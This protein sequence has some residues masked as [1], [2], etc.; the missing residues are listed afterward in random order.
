MP[1]VT[2]ETQTML[3][4]ARTWDGTVID[5]AEVAWLALSSG[6]EGLR[7]DVR[8]TLHGDP[9]PA[10]PP[11]SCDRLWEHEVVELFIAGKDG[12]YLEVELGPHGHYLVLRFDGPRREVGRG[13]GIDYRVQTSGGR[14]RGEALIPPE[15]LPERPFRGNAFAMHGQGARRR[16]LAAY[17]GTGEPDFHRQ[18]TYE[19]LIV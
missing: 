11:G 6:D 18:D 7:V 12:R 10:A 8:G 1:V 4:V 5:Q 15:L 17:S 14:W 3:T 13:Y 2:N 19:R 16:Y 9:P